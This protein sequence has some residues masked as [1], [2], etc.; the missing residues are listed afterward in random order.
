METLFS[1]ELVRKSLLSSYHKK[2]FNDQIT[3]A[4]FDQGLQKMW[5]FKDEYNKKSFR[6]FVLL[7]PLIILKQYWFNLFILFWESQMIK[8]FE[9]YFNSNFLPSYYYKKKIIFKKV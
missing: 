8:V 1:L 5:S 7:F 6:G 3:K 9:I 2:Q 4:F